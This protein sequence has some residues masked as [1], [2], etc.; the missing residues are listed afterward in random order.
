MPRSGPQ[1]HA[2]QGFGSMPLG[3]VWSF[4][5][6]KLSYAQTL[7]RH[8]ESGGAD[9][10]KS[11]ALIAEWGHPI[12]LN[13][14]LA[15]AIFQSRR[16]N[17]ASLAEPIP[18]L[19]TIVTASPFD[20]ADARCLRQAARRNCFPNLGPGISCA[21]IWRITWARN[22]KARNSTFTYLRKPCRNCLSTIGWRRRSHH[23]GGHQT[24]DRRR[25]ARNS[26]RMDPLQ[27]H[28][29]HQNQAEWRRSRLGYGSR[30]SGTPGGRGTAVRTSS[31]RSISTKNA[32]MW[33]ICSIFC[34]N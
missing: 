2:A 15:A 31:I 4:P 34:T 13:I 3:N 14:A 29:P 24:E 28:H 17:L 25:P 7:R 5:S 8:E 23:R 22:S 18:P 12:D 16:G 20:A 11:P 10:R 6:N 19:C 30:D 26:A 33:R 32:R 1:R 21:T 9:R 27:R